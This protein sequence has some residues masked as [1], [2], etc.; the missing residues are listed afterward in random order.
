[1]TSLFALGGSSAFKALEDELAA[2]VDGLELGICIL[3]DDFAELDVDVGGAS[4][5]SWFLSFSR[6]CFKYKVLFILDSALWCPVAVD[7]TCSTR[8]KKIE[9]LVRIWYRCDPPTLNP[10]VE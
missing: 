10:L 4:L 7:S 8:R 2:D 6:R 5:S 3:D 9:L 1:M